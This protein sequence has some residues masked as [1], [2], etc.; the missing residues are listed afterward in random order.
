MPQGAP[1]VMYDDFNLILDLTVDNFSLV[2]AVRRG[3]MQNGSERFIDRDLEGENSG[4]F[5]AP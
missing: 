3:M 5:K 2:K 4:L 1:L